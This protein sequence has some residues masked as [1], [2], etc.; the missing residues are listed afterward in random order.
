[1]FAAVN[2]GRRDAARSSVTKATAPPR[3]RMDISARK[4][5]YRIVQYQEEGFLG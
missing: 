3:R 2:T 1:M 4:L 5:Y